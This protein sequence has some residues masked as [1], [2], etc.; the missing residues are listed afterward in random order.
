MR[1]FNFSLISYKTNRKL[2]TKHKLKSIIWQ[3]LDFPPNILNISI[4]T[5][6]TSITLLPTESQFREMPK[7]PIY[8][9]KATEMN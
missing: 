5:S 6:V 8:E 4:I 9:I 1:K 2:A 7:A 3:E